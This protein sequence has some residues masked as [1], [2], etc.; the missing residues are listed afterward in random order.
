MI[1]YLRDFTSEFE[2]SFG[3]G[4]LCNNENIDEN[5]NAFLSSRHCYVVEKISWE[6]KSLFLH[7]K[8]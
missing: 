8:I 6:K 4:K 1:N 3:C 7:L 5:K 2:L